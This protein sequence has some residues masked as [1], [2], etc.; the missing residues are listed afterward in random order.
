MQDRP[1]RQSGYGIPAMP[2]N[3]PEYS[4]EE[5]EGHFFKL[6]K[7]VGAQPDW[8]WDQAVRASVKDSMYRAIKDPRERRAAFDRYVAHSIAQEKEQEKDRRAKLRADFTAMLRTHDE[9]KYYTRWSS[10]LR[11][12]AKETLFRAAKDEDEKQAIFNDYRDELYKKH[13]E[14][15]SADRSVALDQLE[16][17][18]KTLDLEPYTRWAEAQG[19]IQSSEQFQ[20]DETFKALQKIDVVTAFEKHIKQLERGFNDRLQ[21][22]KSLKARKERQNRDVFKQLLRELKAAGT[23]KAG[24]KWMAIQPLIEEDPRYVAMLGQAGSTPLDL[25]WD[26]TED[27]ERLLEPLKLDVLDTLEVWSSKEFKQHLLT[28]PRKNALK[29]HLRLRS[30]SSLQ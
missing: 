26:I 10:A 18:L 28:F 22:E 17:L 23:I 21:K 12:I 15:E 9:I 20:G 5:A 24:S 19:I 1:E 7:R 14:Q 4:K 6:L 27:L 11:F 8:T 2:S 29:S 25:F 13:L 16:E 3:E 30:K